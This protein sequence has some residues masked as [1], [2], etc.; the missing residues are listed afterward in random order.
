MQLLQHLLLLQ[1]RL[2]H[3]DDL[4]SLQVPQLPLLLLIHVKV[5]NAQSRGNCV[6]KYLQP[7]HINF[8]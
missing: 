4:Q 3:Q 5:M 2:F 7:E 1:R 6:E 8:V